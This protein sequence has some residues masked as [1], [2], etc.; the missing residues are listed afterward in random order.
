MADTGRTYPKPH[1]HTCANCKG[2]I[3]CHEP[4]E[5]LDEPITCVECDLRELAARTLYCREC[6]S[7]R[8]AW[9]TAVPTTPEELL[10]SEWDCRVCREIIMCDEC[11]TDWTDAHGLTH[12]TN[13]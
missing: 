3:E 6:E 1:F 11:G 4:D 10:E 7:W 2:F 8:P 5:D 12:A 13:P 9:P